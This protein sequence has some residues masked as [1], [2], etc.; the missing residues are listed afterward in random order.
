M[1]LFIGFKEK[2]FPLERG[3]H[4]CSCLYNIYHICFPYMTPSFYIYQISNQNMMYK[5]Q[6]YK[7]EIMRESLKCRK[8]NGFVW[9]FLLS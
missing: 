2:L 5:V 3:I 1:A 7:N 9:F 4:N 8:G 6:V